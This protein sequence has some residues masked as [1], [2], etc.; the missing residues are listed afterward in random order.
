MLKITLDHIIELL[1]HEKYEELKEKINQLHPGDAA[2]IINELPAEYQVKVF[3]YLSP[4][5]ASDVI[6]DLHDE[7]REDVLESIQQNRLVEIIDEMDSDEATDIAA[8]LADHQLKDVLQKIDKEDSDEIKQLLVYDEDTA[9]GIMQK[10]II[11]V[12][13]E[14]NRAE[15]IDHIRAI[16]DDVEKLYYIF[17][18]DKENKLIGI[19]EV[20]KLLLCHD[21][22]KAVD[23]MDEDVISAP[24]GMDQEEVARIFRKYDIYILPVV[25]KENHLLGRIT[26]DDI[27]DV[28]DDEASEDVYKMVGLE[29]EDKV[30]TS[31]LSSVKKRLPW[32]TL[33]LFTALLVSSVVG[34]FEGTI[35]RLSFLAVLMPIVAG[36]G[37]NSGTQTLTVITRGIALGELTLHNTYRAIVKEIT[38][39]I[40]N[41]LLIGSVAMLIAYL[42]KGN[43]ILGAVLGISMVCNMFIAGLVGSSIPV[44][45]KTLKIDPALASSVII[46]MLTDI[47]GFATFLGLAT[48]ML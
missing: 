12:N 21:E 10:E 38:V 24:V 44:V 31:P 2:Q 42:L 9:G 40:I 16:Y 26:V 15:M 5:I 46:T 30:F 34:I 33:N 3:S 13:K 47:G 32:L 17:V 19:L 11:A 39:G 35:A 37:G 25:D 29:N 43:I 8:E 22:M 36:L 18:T 48:L 45:M 28:I 6:N 7:L 23:I 20:S 41:G 1:E 27:I 4:E 14:M